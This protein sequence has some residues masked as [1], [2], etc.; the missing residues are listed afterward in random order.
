MPRSFLPSVGTEFL[1]MYLNHG[2]D[3]EDHG[4]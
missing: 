1:G 2:V 4:S 3:H